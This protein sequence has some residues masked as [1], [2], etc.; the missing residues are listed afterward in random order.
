MTKQKN[1][2]WVG[3][4]LLSSCASKPVV[5]IPDTNACFALYDLKENKMVEV[6]NEARCKERFAACST[7]K[8]PLAVMGFDS[9]ILKDER[10]KF[11]GVGLRRTEG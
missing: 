5:L 3:L 1:I 2:L 9:G 10:T 8:I 6:V 7:F 4:W 11:N